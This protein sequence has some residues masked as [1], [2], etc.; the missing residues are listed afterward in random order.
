MAKT[1]RQ[2]FGEIQAQH[3]KLTEASNLQAVHDEILPQYNDLLNQAPNE[4]GLIFAVATANLQLGYNGTAINLYRRCIE[5]AG[6]QPEFWNNLGS[7][8]KNEHLNDDARECFEKALEL[9]E[10]GE[11]YSNISTLY[12]NEGDPEKGLEYSTKSLDLDG[13]NPKNHWNHALLLLEAGHYDPG[14][15][16]YDAGLIS[17][18]RPNRTYGNVPMWQSDDLEGLRGKTVVVYGEQGIGDE[19]LFATAIPDLIEA[20]GD[21]QVIY[22]CHDRLETVMRRSFPGVVVHPTRKGPNN[23]SWTEYV[24]IDYRIAIGSLFRWFGVKQRKPYLVADPDLVRKYREL[25]QANGPGPYIGVG[26]AGGAKK[27]H[28]HERSFK[29]TPLRPILEQKATFVSLQYTPESTQK[30]ANWKRDTG[31]NVLHWPEHLFSYREDGEKAEGWNYEHTI[32]MVAAC[33]LIIVPNTAVVH[34]AG[35]LGTE[36][37]SMTPIKC[38]WRYLNGGVFM[39]WYGPHVRLFREGDWGWDDTVEDVAYFLKERITTKEEA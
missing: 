17:G 31:I 38:A 11:Y 15:I 25:Y 19:L 18:D 12:I 30:W 24:K 23:P 14:F 10:C 39:P 3:A 36:C 35:A 4:A 21:G 16:E 34:V 6:D 2:L 32:A 29:L 22:D 33:D 1:L 28:G 27:T 20:V 8:Y 37:W 9:R 5:L 7:A 13:K 26:Y